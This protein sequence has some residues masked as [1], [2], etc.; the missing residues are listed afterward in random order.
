MTVRPGF[1]AVSGAATFLDIRRAL[2]SE[3]AHSA[4]GAIRAGIYPFHTNALVT[5]KATMAVDVGAFIAAIDRNGLVRVANDGTVSVSISAAPGSGSRWSVVYVKQRESGAPMSDGADGPVIDKVESTTSLSAARALL[6]VGALEFGTVEVPAGA[7]ATNSVGV[8]ITQ[9]YLYTA[10]FGGKVFVRNS[11]EL[12]AWS[13]VDGSEAFQIDT[14]VTYRR[15][16]GAWKAWESDWATYT[17]SYVSVT[18]GSGGSQG[19]RW[20]LVGGDIEIDHGLLW[21][22]AG[23]AIDGVSGVVI[24]IPDGFTMTPDYKLYEHVGQGS[25]NAD[26]A[27][28]AP[29]PLTMARVGSSSTRLMYLAQNSS[30]TYITEGNVGYS[31][32]VTFTSTGTVSGRARVRVA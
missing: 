19:S 6:P 17:P 16:A 7:S 9:T 30:G 12:A 26:N 31:A 25:A 8:V 20:R 21:G 23:S 11:T 3:V 4:A 18:P 14:G 28:S 27:G 29:S 5:S 15:I 10:P 13:P 1:P 24:S 2:E 22:G 32:P